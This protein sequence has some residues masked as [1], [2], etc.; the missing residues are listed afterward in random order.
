LTVVEVAP[1]ATL[2]GEFED[3]LLSFCTDRA[4]GTIREDI[5]QGISVWVDGRVYFQ[6]KD[7]KKHLNTN[8]F[9]SYSSN[10]ITLRLQEM[11]AEKMFW[12]VKEKGVHV[13]SFPQSMFKAVDAA[14]YELAL[15]PLELDKE[16]F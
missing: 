1:D 4:K 11:Q 3:L 14:E 8:D 2:K 7:L 9:T 12:R 13:W 16:H 10:K 6:I 5:L 15:P